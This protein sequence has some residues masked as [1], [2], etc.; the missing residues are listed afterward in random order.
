MYIWELPF[1]WLPN[2]RFPHHFSAILANPNSDFRLLQPVTLQCSPLVWAASQKLG[3][4]QER[5]LITQK[6]YSK[7]FPFLQVLCNLGHTSVPLN[8]FFTQLYNGFLQEGDSERTYSTITWSEITVTNIYFYVVN[9]FKVSPNVLIIY[10]MFSLILPVLVPC[11]FHYI[12]LNFVYVLLSYLNSR[13]NLFETG[14][15]HYM[16]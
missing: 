13:P 12:I 11:I 16:Y 9:F 10:C 6:F 2:F 5:S 3:C 7:C 15:K 4:L 14:N 1:S 8:N